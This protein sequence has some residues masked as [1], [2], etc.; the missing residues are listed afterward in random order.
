MVMLLR[1]LYSVAGFVSVLQIATCVLTI[2]THGQN[3]PIIKPELCWREG[4]GRPSPAAAS[5]E[6]GN[7]VRRSEAAP[8]LQSQRSRVPSV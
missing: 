7:S 3:E 2:A 1:C 8:D 4:C 5:G 6:R